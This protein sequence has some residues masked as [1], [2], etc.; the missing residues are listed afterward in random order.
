M[1]PTK[2]L[3][4]RRKRNPER[5]P[6]PFT[7]F[8][9]GGGRLF[10]IQMH[11]ARRLH[12]DLRIE[13]GGVLKSWAV[14][15]GPSSRPHEKR[16]AV[17]VEDH[18]VEYADFEGIIP[19]GNYGAGPVI[20]WDRGWYRSI[21]GDDLL[22][23]LARG[24]IEV[25][26]F[27]FK[28]RGQWTL[29]RM[30]GKDKEWLLL[31]KA[32]AFAAEEELV[33]RYPESV[34][35]GL[36]VEELGRA[37]AK[38]TALRKRLDS[39]KLPPINL[40]SRHP[41]PMLASIGNRPFSRKD[42]LFEIKY[43][44]VRV[45]AVRA[46]KETQLLGRIGQDITASYPEITRALRVL[47]LERFIID[48]EIVALDEKGHPSFQRLQQRMHLK[49]PLDIE[50]ARS[51]VPANAIFF[52]CLS[53]NERDLR[54]LPLLERKE[55]LKLFLPARGVIRYGDHVLEHGEAFFEAACEQRLEGIVA[56]RTHSRYLAGRSKDWVKIK[57]QLRQEFVIGGYTD[58]QGTRG[59]FGALHLGLYQ[60]GRLV[61][62]SKVGTGFDEKTLKTIWGML[63]PLR[64]STTPFEVGAPSGRGNHWLEPKLVCEVRFTDWTQ[65]RGIRHPT[66]LG[67]RNDKR[68]EDCYG[69]RPPEVI[70]PSPPLSP[71]DSTAVKIT[72]PKKV[73][74]PNEGYTKADL[75]AYY[76]AAAPLILPYLKDRPVV[77]TRYPEGIKGRS[78]FQKDA[79]DF[80][81]DWVRTERIYSKDA[82]REI[83]YFV[84][85]DAKT[86]RYVINL[87]T[88]PLHL[89]SSRLD[90][91]DR[92]DWLVLDLDPKGAPFAHV[93][94]VAA[95]LHRILRE[96][97]LPGY[98]KTSGATGLHILVPLGA[99]Y[100]HEEA[101]TFAGLLASLAV[102]AEPELATIARPIKAR[103]GKVYI[104]YVQNGHGR[105]IVA[106]FSVRPLPGTPV[107]CPLRWEELT[108]RLSPGKFTIRSV[109]AR[110]EKLADPMRSVLDGSIDMGA[111]LPRIEKKLDVKPSATRD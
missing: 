55:C 47:P 101:R 62:V 71:P 42:W 16:L 51:V 84:I 19:P 83:D 109:R 76:E 37:P 72:N 20:V 49:N 64:R 23:Q 5:T 110:F 69:E 93:V 63:Q 108:P 50:Q 81:P 1:N 41:A 26:F 75:I 94:K 13:M 90:S 56:K 18:P 73:F 11:S 65:D 92:P 15:K 44:G 25:E 38:L 77:L 40:S 48:G 21:K 58:P 111:A 99:E 14:P 103:D 39:L 82:D 85:H 88:I 30:G 70:A 29:A 43:D 98:L 17:H 52:D 7:G 45:L 9:P 67:L 105:T 33:D 31:K 79:P 91:L 2:L 54:S 107:S 3:D 32:D 106:P 78:F 97:R 46:G 80:V 66:F 59:H 24:K 36:T 12:Y 95:A 102:Q 35:S 61:Y 68:P 87:G 60:D 57:C 53:L 89:W 74:W 4:Y 6:E 10:V 100:T 27:G 96:L 86:L 34:L 28:L 8:R 104:D 22:E